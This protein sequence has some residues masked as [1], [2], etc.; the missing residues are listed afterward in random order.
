MSIRAIA[1]AVGV[2]PPSIYLHFAD[3][4]ELMW[5]LCEERFADLDRL[6]EEEADADDPVESLLLRGRAYVRFGL[7]NPEHYRIL[8]MGRRPDRHEFWDAKGPE[9]PGAFVHLVEAVQRCIDAGAF[10]VTDPFFVAT[11]MWSVVHGITSLMIS[12]PAFPWLD[13]FADRV[14]ELQ[15]RGLQNSVPR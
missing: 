6:I 1:D 9:P 8:F 11:A 3:K 13:G 14:L 2:T 12:K 15:L 7:E 5:A 4:D 10:S